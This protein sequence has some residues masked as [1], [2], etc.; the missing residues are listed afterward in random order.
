[1]LREGRPQGH[2]LALRRCRLAGSAFAREE[3]ADGE[4][5]RIVVLLAGRW[6]RSA[7]KREAPFAEDVLHTGKA[8]RAAEKCG[9]EYGIATSLIKSDT[10]GSLVGVVM[11][12]F[13]GENIKA[14]INEHRAACNF[15]LLREI[16]HQVWAAT[17]AGGAPHLH[18]LVAIGMKTQPAELFDNHC[19]SAGFKHP[20]FVTLNSVTAQTVRLVEPFSDTFQIKQLNVPGLM[21]GA[22][23]DSDV[24]LTHLRLRP[25]A[26]DMLFWLLVVQRECA[27]EKTGGMTNIVR[28]P[29]G[30]YSWRRD[31]LGLCVVVGLGKPLT[32]MGTFFSSDTLSNRQEVDSIKAQPPIGMVRN[33]YEMAL[34]YVG[35]VRL[36]VV[37]RCLSTVAAQDD[38][39]KHV[40]PLTT[41]W[42]TTG[43]NGEMEL[44]KFVKAVEPNKWWTL[45]KFVNEGVF[46][47][48]RHCLVR[49]AC[50]APS[51]KKVCQSWHRR[52][53]R[54][55]CS[56]AR[57]CWRC[58]V[59]GIAKR[60]ERRR[61]HVSRLHHEGG[62]CDAQDVKFSLEGVD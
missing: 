61:R 2:S 57:T 49:S 14:A 10:S 8:H 11:K 54:P 22:P 19:Q 1:M 44:Q 12:L 32:E 21:D 33:S 34:R 42:A 59:W 40:Y 35:A 18:G 55:V 36:G 16:E 5:D 37:R 62:R 39:L 28:S 13:I 51:K 43:D 27:H 53:R 7:W 60:V 15:G 25:Y 38:K 29:S 6:K 30:G 48:W 45:F 20:P 26:M 24:A 41:S 58:A 47:A 4:V 52:A 17:D 50:Q 46:L 9:S 56:S 23:C 3:R 31:Q